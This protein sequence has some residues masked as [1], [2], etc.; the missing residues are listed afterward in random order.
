ML[1][2]YDTAWAIAAAAEVAGHQAAGRLAGEA[3]LNAV[4][5]TTFDG[6][7]GKFRL[8]DKQLQMPAAYEIVNIV[9]DGTRTVGFWTEQSRVS[10]DLRPSS[11][12]GLKQIVWPGEHQ[13]AISICRIC[14]RAPIHRRK[15]FAAEL[16]CLGLR[17]IPIL[18]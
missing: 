15:H 5:E 4:V 3:L 6:L 14:E 2:A 17:T 12:R 10:Q 8:V 9:A 7:A 16:M 1:R 18:K 13:S 11:P